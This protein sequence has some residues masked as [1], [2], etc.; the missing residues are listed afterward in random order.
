LEKE[1]D[2]EEEEE[3]TSGCQAV[4]REGETDRGTTN[5]KRQG[6]GRG[7]EHQKYL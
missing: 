3:E 5:S 2:Q 4:W 6:R 7:R 1:I